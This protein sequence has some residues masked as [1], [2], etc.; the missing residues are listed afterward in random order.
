MGCFA[1]ADDIVLLAPTKYA[2]SKTYKVSCKFTS[3]YSMLFNAKKSKLMLFDTYETSSMTI[4]GE[5]FMCTNQE[6]HLG[7]VIGTCK[8]APKNVINNATNDFIKRV[9]VITAQFLSVFCSTKYKHFKSFCMP[10]YGCVLRD[11]S[12]KYTEFF[13]VAWRK[14]IR[15][16]WSLPY[17][18]HCNLLPIICEDLPVEYQLHIRFLKSIKSNMNTDNELVKLCAR[19]CMDGSMSDTGKSLTYICSKYGLIRRDVHDVCTRTL[20]HIVLA[21]IQT[22]PQEA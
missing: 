20:K 22:P 2:L 17:R 6:V 15:L 4:N 18:T 14:S 10:M 11:F 21:G 1:Y 16:L 5:E 13:F 8:N 12:S 3:E 7:N 19:L 9:N